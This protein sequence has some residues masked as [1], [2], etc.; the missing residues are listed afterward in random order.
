[1]FK[2]HG[3]S[4]AH[5]LPLP[6]ISLQTAPNLQRM[7]MQDPTVVF[8]SE[9]SVQPSS[10]RT[11]PSG[12]TLHFIPCTPGLQTHLPVICSQSSRKLPRG[13]HVQGMHPEFPSDILCNP[14]NPASHLSH[15]SPP[16]PGLQWHWLVE[17]SHV[18]E[19]DPRRLQPQIEGHPAYLLL[20]Q[21]F[22]RQG[23][24]QMESRH[25]I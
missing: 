5:W 19:Y 9:I 1:M 21:E 18:K 6:W 25:R 8:V 14:Q 3:C 13:S 20:R 15:W 2:S 24:S 12:Q 4:Q 16:T 11:V 22:F 10:S 7:S 17:G 23:S